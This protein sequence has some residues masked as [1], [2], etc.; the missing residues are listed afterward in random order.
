MHSNNACYYLVVIF[1]L[2]L[3]AKLKQLVC[4]VYSNCQSEILFI[5][6]MCVIKLVCCDDVGFGSCKGND[7]HKMVMSCWLVAFMRCVA[8][9]KM[10]DAL[11]VDWW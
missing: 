4:L 5:I 3:A 8:I 10:K 2:L 7:L 1:L 6:G 9:E 11:L